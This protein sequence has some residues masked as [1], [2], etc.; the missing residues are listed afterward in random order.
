MTVDELSVNEDID[1][2][3]S[4]INEVV[5][6]DS[7]NEIIKTNDNEIKLENT[8]D[9]NLTDDEG[10]FVD[11]SEGYERL[12]AFRTETG[13]WQWNEDNTTKTVFNTNDNNQLKPLIIDPAL[14]ETAKIRAKELVELYEHTRPDGSECWTAFPDGLWAKAENI[15]KGQTS[16]SSVTEA[17]KETNYLYKG[18]GHRRN[19]LN[20]NYNS[21]GIAGYK[22]NGVIYWVQ[23][24]GKYSDVAELTKIN[25]NDAYTV[26]NNTA[27]PIFTIEL[28]SDTTGNFSV[29]IDGTVID[30]K[31]LSNGK[32][33]I[34]ATD[35]STGIHEAI[36]SYSGDN[37]Y[38]TINQ[39]VNINVTQNE[40]PIDPTPTDNSTGTF[41]D[42][43]NLIQNSPE[44]SVIK[45]DKNYT[46]DNNTDYDF[47]IDGVVINK[48]IIIDGQG[49]TINAKN[50][51]RI[52]RINTEVTLKNINFRNANYHGAID[53]FDELF[54]V[55]CTFINNTDKSGGG[56]IYNAFDCSLSVVNSTF[57]NNTAKDGGAI[58]NQ[59]Y[60]DFSFSVVN[61]TFINNNANNV[62]AIGNDYDCS[63]SVV[64]CTFINNTADDG[65]I[66][67]IDF[68]SV[69][70]ST[71][72]NNTGDKKGVI[73]NGDSGLN[74]TINRPVYDNVTV[75]INNKIYSTTLKD[76]NAVIELDNIES[77]KNY[78]VI[79]TFITDNNNKYIIYDN[80]FVNKTSKPKDKGT[81]TD[82]N[83]LI[84]NASENCV[85]KLDKNYTYDNSTDYNLVDGIV[86][87]KVITID[88]QGHT[89]NAN[90]F[91]RIFNINLDDVIIKNIKFIN[92]KTNSWGGAIKY[93]KSFTTGSII[94]CSFVN[95][96]AYKNGGAIESNY[97]SISVVNSTFIN[98]TSNEAGAIAGGVIATNVIFIN[99]S[100]N[101]KG[102]A[103]ST[104]MHPVIIN[105]TFINNSADKGGAICSGADG[106][107][108]VVN[109]TFINN[110]ANNTSVIHST[111]SRYVSVVNSKFINN[112]AK[113]KRS[114]ICSEYED[115]RPGSVS[116]KNSTFIN[117]TA[118]ESEDI[119]ISNDLTLID[120]MFINNTGD[121]NGID[122]NGDNGLNVEFVNRNVY[123]N[124]SI[125]INN[126]KYSSALQNNSAF[127]ELDNIEYGK[128]YEVVLTFA[129]NDN[130]QNINN[131]YTIY[132]NIF[133]KSSNNNAGISSENNTHTEN[134]NQN[135][136][137]KKNTKKVTKITAKKK[138]FKSKKKSKKY[139]IILKTSK[140]AVKKVWVTL[141]ING[142]KFN[143]SFKAK[144]N[145]KG[146]AVFEIK[147][148]TKKGKYSATITFSGNQYYNKA[149]KKVKII[150][151]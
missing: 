73:I 124:I 116:I 134:N 137:P 128:E 56:A 54:V 25:P 146:K 31:V 110:F 118:K 53:N 38:Y 121:K 111:N 49:H 23:D 46:Y 119:I 149:T 17:W 24:F 34:T 142:K 37:N 69:V 95:N 71:F 78:D 135:T 109:S 8:N 100:A 22:Y 97:S 50:F 36:L 59:D 66:I 12:N 82:L 143:K 61:C 16:W 132:D 68:N 30:S 136:N 42:L 103:I 7:N 125:Q 44:N 35:L 98:N 9:D 144:T 89:L 65:V 39:I 141:K 114:V 85:I 27:N 70:N 5:A 87:N 107:L 140:K 19:M 76:N 41:T 57:I 115:R 67:S 108:S 106:T 123:D 147:K 96:Y 86:I 117:N 148:L 4:V 83:N 26:V 18:Q 122:I 126:K 105:S 99:N 104:G 84:Q 21:V 33:N 10:E 64:N 13:V 88:G 58:F 93:S 133:V 6:E 127:I 11:P 48:K 29:R 120:S 139:T 15:A 129:V 130:A 51:A 20:P 91:A 28:P 43:N 2:E 55:N 113:E 138:T 72:I 3:S 101:T 92:G 14:E 150:V 62:G 60:K 80:I 47:F 32:A 112:C 75:Q 1:I 40:N 52:F 94:N 63:F 45:L 151:K 102:G 79:L 74:I 81:F 145:N 90:K 77:S 131:N